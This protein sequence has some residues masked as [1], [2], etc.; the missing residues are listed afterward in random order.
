MFKV[1]SFNANLENIEKA[2]YY[3]TSK[4]YPKPS[5]VERLNVS[6]RWITCQSKGLSKQ[7][8]S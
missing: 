3:N 6:L 5:G 8:P 7:I 4:F 1:S 2:I